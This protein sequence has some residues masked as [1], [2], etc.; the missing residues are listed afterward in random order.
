MALQ[1]L[2]Q[3]PGQSLHYWLGTGCPGGCTKWVHLPGYTN[4]PGGLI[5]KQGDNTSGNNM[6]LGGPMFLFVDLY[7]TTHCMSQFQHYT[8]HIITL[9]QASIVW[10]LLTLTFFSLSSTFIA[11][12]PLRKLKFGFSPYFGITRRNRFL[13]PVFGR[14]S[15]WSIIHHSG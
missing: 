4:Q 14:E 7:S 8:S 1:V 9:V 5:F 11:F 6:R 13:Q 15:S 10:P 2:D 3:R 12:D